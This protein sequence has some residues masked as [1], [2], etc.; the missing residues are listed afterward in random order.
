MGSV[1]ILGFSG[2]GLLNS[3]I[4][5]TSLKDLYDN[6]GRNSN[7]VYISEQLLYGSNSPIV[8]RT[9]EI[10][11]I[12]TAKTYLTDKSDKVCMIVCADSPG[13]TGA[14]TTIKVDSNDK[15]FSLEVYNCG[16]RV[17]FWGNLNANSVRENV[18]LFSKWIQIQI[19]SPN[20]PVSTTKDLNLV[21]TSFEKDASDLLLNG[22]KVLE[23]HDFEFLVTP[24]CSNPEIINSI[25]DY[26][27]RERQDVILAITPPSSYDLFETYK[28]CKSLKVSDYGFVLWPWVVSEK[29]VIPPTGPVLNHL[30]NSSFPWK[31]NSGKLS[32]IDEVQFKVYKEEMIYL[33]NKENFINLIRKKDGL[34]FDKNLR[35][36]AGNRLADRRMLSYVKREVTKLGKSLLKTYDAYGQNFRDKFIKPC[37]YILEQVK[38]GRGINNYGI[39]VY[40]LSKLDGF[41]AIINLVSS[42]EFLNIEFKF[43]RQDYK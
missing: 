33:S 3:P 15:T 41:L 9:D 14:S 20:L 34:F 29:K 39:Q 32:G 7:L 22:I 28:W 42:R 30:L 37:E 8:M 19:L 4:K 12:Q 11:S 17:E 40:E 31:I 2:K 26:I 36:L 23:D 6:F 38:D 43:I 16:E 5:V 24:D 25:L 35:T 10:S 1:A 13:Y 21:D 18:N 27:E